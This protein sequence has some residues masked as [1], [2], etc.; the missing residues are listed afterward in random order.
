MK[1]EVI[2]AVDIK[3]GKCVQLIQGMPNNVSWIGNDPIGMAV[4]WVEDGAKT[5]HLIDLDGALEG[6]LRNSALIERIIERC[7]VKTQ[8]GGGIRSYDSAK[9]L[10][11][12]GADRIILGTAAIKDVSLLQKLS[13]EY[14]SERI[15]VSLDAKKGEVMIEGWKKSS[16]LKIMDV[17]LDLQ[18]LGVGSILFTNID[19]EGLLGGVNQLLIRELVGTVDIPVIASGGVSS[20]EDLVE[21]KNTGAAGAV[22]GT[23]LYKG[24]L[25][26]KE[27]MK[28]IK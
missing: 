22:V 17:G 7:P 18:K 10:F 19:V 1:F 13:S 16:G 6:E 2:P 12:I 11:D 15:M 26:L 9:A 23:A 3:D 27:A 4:R 14:G 25:T 24:N 28:V 20:I 5:L 21:I 8:V